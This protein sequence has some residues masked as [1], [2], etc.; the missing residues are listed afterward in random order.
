M[1]AVHAGSGVEI[2]AVASGHGRA[3]R[4]FME[5]P[6]RLY[7][8]CPQWVPSFRRDTKTILDR[9][10]PFFASS[11]AGFFLARRNGRPAGTIAAIDNRPYNDHHRTRTGQFY[12]FESEDDPEVARGL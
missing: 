8:G 3:A 5:L 12:F 11:T 4:E 7:R 9:K 2:E 10:N 6:F 1:Q